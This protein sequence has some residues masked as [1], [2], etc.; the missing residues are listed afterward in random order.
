MAVEVCALKE[1]VTNVTG[2]MGTGLGDGEHVC[3]PGVTKS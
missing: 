3:I 2:D 1:R